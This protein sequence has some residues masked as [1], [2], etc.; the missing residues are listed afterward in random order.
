ML[1]I[2]MELRLKGYCCSQIIMSIA[3]NRF[4]MDNPEI[5]KAM[6][7]LCDG[8]HCKGTCGIVTAA[9]C[10]FAL[11]EEEGSITDFTEWFED[12]YG[13]LICEELIEDDP[14]IKMTKCP[15]MLEASAEMIEQLL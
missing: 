10:V 6:H 1:E 8:F 5:I 7:G 2:I 4:H 11:A 9:A 13:S 15:Q 12:R 14:M 3:L